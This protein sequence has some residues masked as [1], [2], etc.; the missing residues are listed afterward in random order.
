MTNNERIACWVG[1]KQHPQV[2]T[3]WYKG[4]PARL[5][6]QNTFELP[7]YETSDAV[8]VTLLNVLVERGY[9]PLVGLNGT[10]KLWQCSISRFYMHHKIELTELIIDS[11]EGYSTI[12]A[13]ITSAI[14]QL[15]EGEPSD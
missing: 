9:C 15:I 11:E 4:N 13:A 8:A 1:Y 14:L 5:G 7:D 3:R 6:V 10:T 12:P 2:P